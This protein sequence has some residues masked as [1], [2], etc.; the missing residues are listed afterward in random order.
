MSDYT[1][2]NKIVATL[3]I[4]S[5]FLLGCVANSPGGNVKPG[6]KPSTNYETQSVSPDSFPVVSTKTK[7]DVVI[8]V[9]DP[10]LSEQA[11]NYEEEGIWPELRRAEANRFAYKLKQA[12]DKTGVFGAVRVTPDTQATGDLYL[13]GE[14]R[15]SDGEDVSIQIS[16]VDISGKEWLDKT[17]SHTVKEGFYKD[18][19]KKGQDPYDPLFDEAAI[20]IIEE[21]K[22]KQDS[23][24]VELQQIAKLRFGAS[25]NAEAFNEYMIQ[26]RG[27]YKVASL[28]SDN[29]PMLERVNAIQIREQLFVD[30]LQQNYAG[31]SNNMEDS[32]LKWQEASFTEKKLRDE[33][34]TEGVLKAIGGAL[35]LGLSIAAAVSGNSSS[36][37]NIGDVAQSTA[38]VAGGIAGAW[39]LSSS[40]QS[41]EEAKFHKESIDEL[42][43]SVNM[44]MAPQVVSFEEETVE[45]T[46]NAK[47]QYEQWRAF[48]QR[49]YEQ[50]ATPTTQL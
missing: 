15:Q 14:I 49:I 33:A 6:P 45:L 47:E 41:F 27:Y 17:F 34:Q 24:L 39:M 50:E 10:G 26:E 19:R 40:F 1:T 13:M 43:E 44:E 32:Y 37:V 2:F 12:L 22:D 8:P 48:L 38:V 31:F 3:L 5:Q 20:A 4:Y 7:L 30:N 29:D 23:E 18:I 25:F 28:P 35:L 11:E 42:G 21:L 9:F 16:A 46:G 36:S